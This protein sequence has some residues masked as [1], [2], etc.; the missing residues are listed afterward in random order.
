MNNH[1]QS[2]QKDSQ[3]CGATVRN[4]KHFQVV[5]RLC[6]QDQSQLQ[7]DGSRYSIS[8]AE[9][10]RIVVDTGRGHQPHCL[11]FD[12]VWDVF[13]TQKDL[14][15]STAKSLVGFL[16]Q[17]Y[18]GCVIAYGSPCSGKTYTMMGPSFTGTNRGIISR[19][20]ED[21]FNSPQASSCRV[22]VSFYHI[23]NEKIYDLLDNQPTEV[24]RIHDGEEAVVLEGLKEV[25]VNSLQDLIQLYRRGAANR[26]A[27]VT[28]G[29]F[30]CRSH[31]IFNIMVI[32]TKSQL[33]HAQEG[34]FTASK[35]TLVDLA[36]A[37]K[38]FC[39]NNAA[40]EL[41]KSFQSVQE[42]PQEAKTLKR[43]LTIFG[44]VIFALS[45]SG[46]HVP[47]RESKLTRVL[48]DCLGGNCRTSLVVTVS[49]HVSSVTETLSSLQFASRAMAVPARPVHCSQLQCTP[50]R[51]TV[52]EKS[53]SSL[54]RLHTQIPCSSDKRGLPRTCLPPILSGLTSPLRL[55]H[56]CPDDPEHKAFLPQLEKLRPGSSSHFGSAGRGNHSS[57]ERGVAGD[58]RLTRSL[59]SRPRSHSSGL[60]VFSTPQEPGRQDRV[61][62]AE[63]H[64]SSSR[65]S[66]ERLSSCVP[67]TLATAPADCP[68]CKREKKIR[69]EYDRFIVQARK[70]RD[71]LSQR[72][73][74][75]EATLLKSENA[76]KI[77]NQEDSEEHAE[78]Q[79]E[80]EGSTMC[81]SQLVHLE[82]EGSRS[83][84]QTSELGLREQRQHSTERERA[85]MDKLQSEHTRAEQE[86]P[87]DLEKSRRS[88]RQ[89]IC[90]LRQHVERLL[91]E[92]ENA[93]AE[94]ERF[95]G[96]AA[97]TVAQLQKDKAE[98]MSHIE[99]KK[100]YYE[101]VKLE[102]AGLRE[103]MD[104][105]LSQMNSR[106][107]YSPH[108]S[109]GLP[110]VHTVTTNT[111]LLLLTQHTS[112]QCM[113]DLPTERKCC[114]NGC[115]GF[116]DG[117][118]TEKCS[119]PSNMSEDESS[120]QKTKDTFKQLRREHS[121]LLD[122]MLI[123]YKREWFAEEAMP[124]VRRTLSKCGMSVEGMD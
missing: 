123:L 42:N 109:G 80:G 62:Q 9:P 113:T 53:G 74:E 83:G 2:E 58:V 43:S 28:R 71:F 48:R 47:Y 38:P 7:T 124:Y 26:Q 57:E 29:E 97:L 100:I 40:M 98:M 36:S 34:G 77:S 103:Q 59:S 54:A 61:G 89:E 30:A 111:E 16:L 116:Q 78:R 121:L 5:I 27:G 91:S 88:D 10:S 94:Q 49:S 31:T 11:D 93:A 20:V 75:L 17:G 3:S 8:V 107:Y 52:T 66:V 85:L 18:N 45:S 14:Y 39:R 69:E 86:L 76:D 70:D 81:K 67:A 120:L 37:G 102:N 79:E 117:S 101:K 35:L 55:S 90:T 12:A 82:S 46:H 51:D 33:N 73:A 105:L 32:N 72:V 13:A 114:F 25:E 84:F 95:K 56:R 119:E 1:T 23:S 6:P 64:L 19:A 87:S 110:H 112:Q 68:N 63:M 118:K 24:T 4:T 50:L 115:S 44:N 21:I 106:P 122:V 108:G 92:L 104:A 60:N 96:N 65:R 22:R 99:N 15:E 41:K